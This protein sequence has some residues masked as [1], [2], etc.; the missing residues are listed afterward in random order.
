MIHHLSTADTGQLLSGFNSKIK[1]ARNGHHGAK[2]ENYFFKQI[3]KLSSA[4]DTPPQNCSHHHFNRGIKLSSKGS[5]SCS[6][7]HELFVKLIFVCKLC[8]KDS[9][10]CKVC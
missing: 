8:I 9:Q 7:K 6:Q 2:S 5:A 10:C 4:N 1:Q 3:V